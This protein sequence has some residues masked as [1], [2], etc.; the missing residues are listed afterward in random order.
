MMIDKISLV[1]AMVNFGIAC[2]TSNFAAICGW[3]CAILYIFLAIK[4]N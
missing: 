3:F 4:D 1:L 2:F